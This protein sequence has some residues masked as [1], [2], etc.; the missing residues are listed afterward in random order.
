MLSI[1]TFLL[2]IVSPLLY[3]ATNHIDNILLGRYFREGGVGTLMLFSALLSRLAASIFYLSD[4]TVLRTDLQNMLILAVVG[5][6]NVILLWCYLQAIFEDEPTVV[7]IY[8]QLVPVLGLAMGYGILGETIAQLQVVAMTII[9]IGALILTV[10]QDDT[11]RIKFQF[12]TAV[13]MLVASTCWALE[14]TL[15][16]LVALE[17]N[18]WRSLFWE[19]VVLFCL[20]LLLLAFVPVYRQSFV[21]ALRVNS[22]PILTLNLTNEGL[23]MLANTV[24]AYVVLLIPVALTLLMNLFQPLFVLVLGLLLTRAF[25]N[26]GVE[27]I[28]KRNMLQKV[29]A[30]VLTAIGTFLLGDWATQVM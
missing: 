29:I 19:H 5:V 30:I 18:V 20:G 16:K 17:E 13:Y 12:R 6:V 15:F 14:S 7:I 10:A 24:A 25:P 11:G 27:H 4:P 1:S 3:A 23:F 22:A 9:I 8:Y 26:L 2:A 21:K 28:N